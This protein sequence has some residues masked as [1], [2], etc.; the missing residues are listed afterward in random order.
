MDLLYLHEDHVVEV[1]F[2]LML[3]FPADNVVEKKRE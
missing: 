1:A 3:L 2:I